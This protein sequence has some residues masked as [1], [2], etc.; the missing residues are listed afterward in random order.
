M[1]L[2]HNRRS[3]YVHRACQQ[4]RRSLPD[5][6]RPEYT[7][8]NFQKSIRFRTRCCFPGNDGKTLGGRI[9]MEAAWSSLASDT[10]AEALWGGSAFFLHERE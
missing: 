7:E 2:I 4:R 10:D 3:G 5:K 1:L 6:F 9:K 8:S